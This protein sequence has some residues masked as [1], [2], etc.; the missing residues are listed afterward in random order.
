MNKI[1]FDRCE[2]ETKTRT[3]HVREAQYRKLQE[4]SKETDISIT[5]LTAR[6]LD[7]ALD[8]VEIKEAG[9]VEG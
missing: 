4:I 2:K 5:S 6:L 7:Y 3:V 8:A 1:Y 9:D